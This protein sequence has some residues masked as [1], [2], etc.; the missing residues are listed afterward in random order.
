MGLKVSDIIQLKGETIVEIGGCEKDSRYIYFILQDGS[1]VDMYH[2]QDCC[3][4]VTVEDVCGNPDNLLNSPIL[5]A[6]EANY[7]NAT[8]LE[9]ELPEGHYSFTWTYYKLATIKGYVTIRWF[10]SSN[11]YYSE[12]V[13]IESNEEE[14]E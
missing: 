12:K 8:P 5:M 4:I 6:E 1:K 11:G 9:K 2:E 3:E 14:G 10:G 13:T 7:H